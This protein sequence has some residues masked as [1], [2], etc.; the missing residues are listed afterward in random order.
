MLR[1]RY[2]GVPEDPRLSN[3]GHRDLLMLLEQ[4]L[5][6]A[7]NVFGSTRQ[8]TRLAVCLWAIIS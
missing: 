1:L 2:R 6:R 4:P 5:R 7:V 3:H 8:I